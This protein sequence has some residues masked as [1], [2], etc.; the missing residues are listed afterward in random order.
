MSEG[1]V[2]LK[3]RKRREVC[4]NR[5]SPLPLGGSPEGSWLCR[6][7]ALGVQP[8]CLLCP[9]K[10]GAMKPTR[11][12]TK[13]VHVSCALWIPEVGTLLGGSAPE[14]VLPQPRC[15][16]D[17]P[18]G[19]SPW[20]SLWLKGVARPSPP[21]PHSCILQPCQGAAMP[22]DRPQPTGLT[23]LPNQGT[24]PRACHGQGP[25]TAQALGPWQQQESWSV[26]SEPKGPSSLASK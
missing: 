7:C 16:R 8:K 11:S 23:H 14:P 20:W 2:F 9:K 18:L 3:R 12:G 10:G 19:F 1:I 17:L 5:L 25:P 15:R 4:A 21:P 26:G 13:W 22:Q 6:T 24:G